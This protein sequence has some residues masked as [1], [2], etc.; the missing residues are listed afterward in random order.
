MRNVGI[1]DVEQPHKLHKLDAMRTSEGL[2][3]SLCDKGMV[4]LPD[5]DYP[6]L[7]PCEECDL[8]ARVQ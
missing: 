7:D 2:T 4:L 8:M 1:V 5:G 6:Q 3:W